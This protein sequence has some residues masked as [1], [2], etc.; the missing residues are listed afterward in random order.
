[1]VKKL[2]VTAEG[3]TFTDVTAAHENQAAIEAL[4]ARGI[5]HGKTET[6][7][8]P[9]GSM[10]RAEF[11][12][13][14]VNALGLTPKANSQFTDV[15]ASAWYAPYIGTA[16][17]YGIVSGTSAATFHPSGTI[18]RQ[19]AAAMVARAA[20]LCGMN[21]EMDSAAVRD[22]LAQFTDYVQTNEWARET[23]AFCYQSGILDDDALEI[24]PKTAIKRGEI[25]QMLFNMLGRAELL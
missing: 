6:T 15:A 19:E 24:Q 11:A 13:I 9:N 10:T 21:T 22:M 18:T 20:G 14:V 16:Y 2:P 8:D 25:A 17:S 1:D 12:T 7:F 4:A 5:V 3:R 23:L